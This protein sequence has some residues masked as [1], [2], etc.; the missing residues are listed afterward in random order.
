MEGVF[1]SAI[2]EAP[3]SFQAQAAQTIRSCFN[4]LKRILKDDPQALAGDAYQLCFGNHL[5]EFDK[6]VGLKVE[7]ATKRLRQGLIEAG[8]KASKSTEKGY[9]HEAM[10]PVYEQAE[11]ERPQKRQRLMDV[12]HDYLVENIP[13]LE[14]SFP[15]VA[16]GVDKDGREIITGT[17]REL[18]TN[19]LVI[20]RSIREA[21]EHQ[22]NRKENDTPAG[23]RFRKELHNL[24][25]EALRILKG[26]VTESLEKCKEYK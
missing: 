16:E 21:F 20:L 14:G 15:K 19:V 7:A 24:V 25:A 11:A 23:Q 1:R 22:K 10:V 5:A 2:E 4:E 9:F 26:V 17:C 8:N 12:R 18:L 13:G 3:K 6:D